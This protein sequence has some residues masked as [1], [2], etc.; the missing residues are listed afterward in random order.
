MDARTDADD[1]TGLSGLQRLTERERQCL[2]ALRD[3]GEAKLAARALSISLGTFN[4]HLASSR[5]KLG[6]SRS[7]EAARMA[8]GPDEAPA[9][10][11]QPE[12][13]SPTVSSG[14]GLVGEALDRLG[15]WAGPM[16]VSLTAAALAAI[17]VVIWA[18]AELA[19]RFQA[20]R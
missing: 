10:A 2:A 19:L 20:L 12:I 7:W 3:H 16:L 15:A 8:M 6:V 14:R 5:R 1:R 18:T 11:V 17:A 9:P 13:A 4:D